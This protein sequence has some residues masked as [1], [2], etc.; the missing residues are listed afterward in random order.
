[1]KKKKRPYLQ[2]TKLGE[3]LFLCFEKQARNNWNIPKVG[4]N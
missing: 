4:I 3:I 2:K 1:M